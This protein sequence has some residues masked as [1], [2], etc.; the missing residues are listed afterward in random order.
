[1][2]ETIAVPVTDPQPLEPAQGESARPALAI[3]P[4]KSVVRK[5]RG[6]VERGLYA[7]NISIR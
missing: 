4:L 1:M 2:L 7:H 3:Y 6:S 5:V